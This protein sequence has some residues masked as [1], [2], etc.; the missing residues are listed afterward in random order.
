MSGVKTVIDKIR[1]RQSRLAQDYPTLTRETR[2]AL[3]AN[4]SV[5]EA[6]LLA[7][8]L[9]RGTIII[10]KFAIYARNGTGRVGI[11]LHGDGEGGEFE[12]SA[13]AEVVRRFYEENF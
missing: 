5:S 9:A 11:Y 1:Q 2:E 12:E 6:A 4:L 13:L 8:A 3:D 7:D 10:G